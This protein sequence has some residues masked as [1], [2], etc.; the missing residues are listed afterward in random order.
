MDDGEKKMVNPKMSTKQL[1]H[2]SAMEIQ[3]V[4]V[5]RTW[6]IMMSDD[7]CRCC[8]GLYLVSAG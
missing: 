2:V 1:K 6:I 3:A 4:A 8:R 5:H 7:V